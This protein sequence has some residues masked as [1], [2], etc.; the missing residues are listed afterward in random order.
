MSKKNKT[1]QVKE[2]MS[3]TNLLSLTLVGG[4]VS[5]KIDKIHEYLQETNRGYGVVKSQK[6]YNRKKNHQ[7]TYNSDGSFYVQYIC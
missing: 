3:N 2:K 7:N 4:Y 5:T 6:T 1:Y